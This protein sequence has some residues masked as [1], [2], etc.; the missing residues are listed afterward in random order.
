MLT[1]REAGRRGGK[2]R[3]KK[4]TAEERQR[5]ARQGAAARSAKLTAKQRSAAARKAAKARW[6]KKKSEASNG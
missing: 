6:N 5:V 1:V 2:A 3:L 4:M